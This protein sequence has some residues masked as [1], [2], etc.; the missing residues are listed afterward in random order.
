MKFS[1]ALSVHCTLVDWWGRWQ[2]FLPRS[3]CVQC[4]QYCTII[5]CIPDRTMKCTLVPN[6]VSYNKLYNEIYLKC[7]LHQLSR[8]VE[9]FKLVGMI[10]DECLSWWHHVNHF[11][12]KIAEL[13]QCTIPINLRICYLVKS[14]STHHLFARIWNNLDENMQFI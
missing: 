1:F 14:S 4:I 9:S 6:N 5:Y 3:R 12:N 2:Q 11:R 13:M 10:I 7:A 8:P